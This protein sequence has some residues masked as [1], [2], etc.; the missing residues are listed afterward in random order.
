MLTDF[1]EFDKA[2]KVALDFAKLDGQTLVLAFP[3]HNTGGMEIGNRASSGSYSNLTVEELID[4]LKG[5]TVTAGTLASEIQ[6]MPGGVT[7]INIQVKTKEL[8]NL[9][10]SNEVAQ[11]II[12]MTGMF[13][14]PS[15]YFISFSYALARV[16]CEHYTVI[17]WTSHGHTGEDVPVW[18]YG[19]CAPKGGMDNTDLAKAAANA[20]GLD[21][22]LLNKWLFND[23]DHLFP[24]W[25][26][27][28]SDPMNP[29][30]RLKGKWAKAEL[31]CSKDLLII[32]TKWGSKHIYN[33]PGVV[34]YAPSTNRVY[35]N[36][37]G[38]FLLKLWGIK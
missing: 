31:P 15:Y 19:P 1:I 35:V 14:G 10:V 8:W 4:P 16:L 23:L 2:V 12:D 29:V 9:D 13:E 28:K 33:L 20:L 32:H 25:I 34:V 7:T 27:D 3:D 36:M 11:E 37:W 22:E 17:G 38:V 21:L 6:A 26:M 24:N 18:A 30:V 5:M